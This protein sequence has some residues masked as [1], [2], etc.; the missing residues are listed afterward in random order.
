MSRLVAVLISV[1]A[2]AT[3]EVSA[4]ES[5]L[6]SA[7]GLSEGRKPVQEALLTDGTDGTDTL[8]WDG[9]NDDAGIGMAEGGT[10]WGAVRLTPVE[11][12]T[13]TS[14]LWFNYT[15][16][17]RAVI[18]VWGAGNDYMPGVLLDTVVS[19]TGIYAWHD[20]PVPHRWLAAGE[21]IWVGVRATHPRG[22]FPLGHDAGPMV[23]LG[24]GYVSFDGGGWMQMK[25]LDPSLDFNWNMRAVVQSAPA[26]LSNQGVTSANPSGFRVTPNPASTGSINIEMQV[27]RASDIRVMI[28]DASGR[29][30]LG[31]SS[32]VDN[33]GCAG[34]LDIHTLS[35]GVYLVRLDA[36]ADVTKLVVQ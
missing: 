15:F 24:G 14:V 30:V 22:T 25:Q 12:C 31:R 3:A 19:T 21:D 5:R 18:C 17:S 4:V 7:A 6:I 13:L 8:H 11:N 10:F 32:P 26:G 23:V 34:P 33:T 35:S 27:T 16:A 36:G 2:L 29:C 1:V 20:V 28:F 9:P